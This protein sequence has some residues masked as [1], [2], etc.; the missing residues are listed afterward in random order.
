VNLLALYADRTRFEIRLLLRNRRAVMFSMLFPLFLLVIFGS[1]LGNQTIEGTSVHFAQ[2]LVAGLLASGLLYSAFQQLGIGIPEERTDGTL[3]RLMGSPAPRS[4]YFV[5]KLSCSLF[6]YVFQVFFLLL[7]GHFSYHIEV[8][9]L[10][11]KWF[12]FAWVS[13]L[14]LATSTMLGIAFSNLGKDGQSAAAITA[15]VVLFFQFTSGVFFIYTQLPH[16][17]QTVAAIFPLKWIAQAMRGVF[18]PA[19]FG[20]NE[21]GGSYEFKEAAVILAAWTVGSAVL[22]RRTFRWLPKGTD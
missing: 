18:L 20:A 13:V 5:G 10:G 16:W 15:P 22:C 9:A 7:I 3:K 6:T 8:P 4:V 12:I 14:G 1:A 19:Y 2:Y 11:L 21:A 17:M